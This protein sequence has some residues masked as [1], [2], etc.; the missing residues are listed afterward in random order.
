MFQKSFAVGEPEH[1]GGKLVRIY[2]AIV[3]N[4][5]FFKADLLW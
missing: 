3:V 2:L 5:D 1:S 4:M